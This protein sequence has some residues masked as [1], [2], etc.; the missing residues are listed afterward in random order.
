VCVCVCVGGGGGAVS[1]VRPVSVTL[2]QAVLGVDWPCCCGLMLGRRATCLARGGVT[3]IP[4]W[5]GPG[6]DPGS[7]AAARALK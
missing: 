3:V 7:T 1:S 4:V 2:S 6:S 5:L